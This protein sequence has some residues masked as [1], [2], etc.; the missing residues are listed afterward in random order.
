MSEKHIDFYDESLRDGVQSLWAMRLAH[1][2]VDAVLDEID[3]AGFR[4][5]SFSINA[6]LFVMS[7][8]TGEDPWETLRLL[9]RKVKKTKLSAI[10]A[11]C[12]LSL[13]KPFDP[14]AIWKLFT[15]KLAEVTGQGC[16]T[17]MSN[18]SD[19]INRFPEWIPFLK[20]LGIETYP[21]I[22]YYP[23]PRKDDAYFVDL[24]KRVLKFKP[25]RIYLKDAGGLLT[26]EVVKTL[27]PAMMKEAHAQDVPVG[28]HTHC[29]S[30]NAGRV[31]VEAMKMGVD[32]IHTCTPPLA[33]GTSHTSI[34]RAIDNARLLGL[35]HNINVEPLKVFEEQLTRI[36]KQENL[37]IG[38]PLE[39]DHG[40]YMHQVPG[41]VRATLKNHLTQI[42]IAHKLDEVLEEVVQVREDI[43]SPIMITP[44]SQFVVS[45]AAVNVAMGERYK[46]II[47]SLIETALGVWGVED[48][49]ARY[50]DPNLKD[51]ILSH[52]NA[53]ALSQKWER[54]K[55]EYAADRPIEY[56][57]AQ[58][59]MSSASD[60]DFLLVY[61]MKGDEEIKKMR[62]AGAPRS[63]YTGKEPLVLL[64]KALSKEKDIS[65]LL[66]Q[67]GN[68]F[69]DFR[70]K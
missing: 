40:V 51:K 58:Y 31:L 66:L 33:N 22:C 63:F 2:I 23:S 57:K 17:F 34:F 53:K 61:V 70:Q 43:G 39:Y 60:E 29:V 69:F 38:V 68:S 3:Q 46:E 20:E 59:G 13:D 26:T 36:A 1:G 27:L 6:L 25:D 32:E 37:P 65:R 11:A 42:G 5:T 35:T 18:P 50:I 67:K 21:A 12:Q 10:T 44:F 9:K 7:V 41:G 28:I 62:A 15:Q 52:P 24:T 47:D 30:T 19:E 45:Q 49:G 8:R 14:P 54:D 48:S 4:A 55:E 16:A 56:Y 64:L